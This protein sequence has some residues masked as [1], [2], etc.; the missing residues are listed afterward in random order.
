MKQFLINSKKTIHGFQNKIIKN[1]IKQDLK[2]KQ[3]LKGKSDLKGKQ[4][5][6]KKS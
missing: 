3:D 5:F 4:D 2:V 1:F 6:K